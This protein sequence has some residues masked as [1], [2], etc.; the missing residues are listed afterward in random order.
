MI[1]D[2]KGVKTAKLEVTLDR[3][4][5]LVVNGKVCIRLQ[6][7]ETTEEGD[8]TFQ[9]NK[10]GKAFSGIQVGL[11][12][13]LFFRRDVER[14]PTCLEIVRDFEFCKCARDRADAEEAKRQ[15]L[16]E[17]KRRE[18]RTEITGREARLS[19][20]RLERAVH[21]KA[22]ARCIEREKCLE[23]EEACMALNLMSSWGVECAPIESFI[24][25]KKPRKGA[26]LMP[27][28]TYQ[29]TLYKTRGEADRRVKS[30]EKNT[31]DKYVVLG[32]LK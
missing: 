32:I 28:N 29:N 4:Y 16:D 10:I 20:V 2:I 7:N 5:R 13:C 27:G 25:K 31:G 24:V 22:L 8:I 30:L 19:A 14:C 15:R 17:E 23:E 9:N 6:P 3:E 12:S 1:C 11:S 18:I 21:E 26:T